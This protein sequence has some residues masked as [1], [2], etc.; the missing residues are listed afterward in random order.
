MISNLILNLGFSKF[1]FIYIYM[2]ECNLL[3][4]KNYMIISVLLA[5]SIYVVFY[6]LLYLYV[7][8]HTYKNNTNDLKE[9]RRDQTSLITD[10][11]NQKLNAI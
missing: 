7:L 3:T 11:I 1:R 4:C 5:I 6:I 9:W 2:I 10:T 8:Y